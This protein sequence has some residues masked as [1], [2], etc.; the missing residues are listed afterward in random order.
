MHKLE[1]VAPMR[2][3]LLLLPSLLACVVAVVV[4]FFFF[5]LFLF[6]F[7]WCGFALTDADAG[8]VLH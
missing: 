2:S 1:S 3:I 7:L 5:F 6:L 4:P 8:F